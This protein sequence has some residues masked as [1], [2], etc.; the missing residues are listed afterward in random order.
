MRLRSRFLGHEAEL[1]DGLWDPVSASRSA[2]ADSLRALSP[3]A[4]LARGTPAAPRR[5][6]RVRARPG[7]KM[8]PPRSP[9][10]APS[11]APGAVLPPG[12]RYLR[13]RARAR[14]RSGAGC[15]PAPAERFPGARL[16]AA[17]C[18]PRSCA[19]RAGYA[20]PPALLP[21]PELP[22]AGRATTAGAGVAVRWRRSLWGSPRDL[23]V[24]HGPEVFPCPV[25]HRLQSRPFPKHPQ[26]AMAPRCH[27]VPRSAP[28][29]CGRCDRCGVGRLGGAG[30]GF[31]DCFFTGGMWNWSTHENTSG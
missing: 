6:G 21:S 17:R 8:A 20:P 30:G 11:G 12:D 25:P 5:G 15:L 10:Q 13:L 18:E 2:P 24:R 26:G 16:P 14:A 22:G 27:L 23:P 3:Q 29:T 7:P 1:C 9:Q 19:P 28:A 4:E 31:L